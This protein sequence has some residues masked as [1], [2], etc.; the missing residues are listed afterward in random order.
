MKHGMLLIRGTI[1]AMLDC[2]T[3]LFSVHNNKRAQPNRT[4]IMYVCGLF[5]C[6]KFDLYVKIVLNKQIDYNTT[7]SPPKRMEIFHVSIN[8]I[9]R[10]GR[11]G[12]YTVSIQYKNPKSQREMFNTLNTFNQNLFSIL[13]I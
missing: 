13:N 4:T 10:C 6:L 9:N 12:G 5:F 2:R 8:K 1:R 11:D 7:K 3:Q